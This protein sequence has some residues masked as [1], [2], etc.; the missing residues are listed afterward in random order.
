MLK[1][2]LIENWEKF[3]E[4][5]KPK[6]MQVIPISSCTESFGNDIVLIF[7]N[8]STFP[9]YIFKSS[10]NST[11]GHKVRNEYRS[12]KILS[13]NSILSNIIPTPLYL[14]EYNEKPFFLQEGIQ[15]TSLFE[16]I[17]NK[18]LNKKT[19]KLVSKSV[20]LL[21]D[22]GNTKSSCQSVRN[23]SV[24]DYEQIH[25]IFKNELNSSSNRKNV[26]KL[27]KHK[28][29]LEK[30]NNSFFFHGDYWQ[31]NIIVDYREESIN[32]IIDWEF[33]ESSMFFPKDLIWFLINLGFCLCLHEDPKVGIRDSYKRVFFSNGR[34]REIV[35]TCFSR[36]MKAIGWDRSLLPVLL[37]MTLFEMS[38]RELLAYGDHYKM[39]NVLK[40]LFVYTI[41]NERN[42]C[43]L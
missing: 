13:A 29:M 6:T 11:F 1:R 41:E 21:V 19:E 16:L 28:Q 35:A 17:K 8:N 33:S 31:T 4:S 14:D 43:A 22:I 2:F 27:I 39:D 5:E 32:G 34:L 10:R 9:N 12:L 15:G 40:E 3:T 24:Y 42:L 26:E 36:Y 30:E 7:I 23:D 20:D 18:G 37:E 38:M 25:G